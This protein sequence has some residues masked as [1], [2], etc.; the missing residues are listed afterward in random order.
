M[1]EKGCIKFDDPSG[2]APVTDPETSDKDERGA[3]NAPGKNPSLVGAKLCQDST[4]LIIAPSNTAGGST[5]RPSRDIFLSR[6]DDWKPTTTS[7]HP[8]RIPLDT[9]CHVYVPLGVLP[10]KKFVFLDRDLW[11]CVL[12]LTG[13]ATACSATEPYQRYYFIPRDWVGTSSLESCVLTADGT[14]FW[15]KDDR[16]IRIKCNLDFARPVV[17]L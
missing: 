1:E 8:Y 9:S 16:V 13:S 6:L 10:G 3:G 4:Y 17:G 15:P 2:G 11:L 12:P 7:I 5:G 14:L